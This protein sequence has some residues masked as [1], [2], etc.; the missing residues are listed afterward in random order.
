MFR[1]DFIKSS[2]LF[3]IYFA[4]NPA[5]AADILSQSSKP[6]K[7]LNDIVVNNENDFRIVVKKTEKEGVKDIIK[8]CE[9]SHYEDAWVYIPSKKLWVEVG[10]D[11]ELHSNCLSFGS[12]YYYD[13]HYLE[14]IMDK[15]SGN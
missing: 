1:R 2:V 11:E 6:I 5:G 3:S 10:I 8:L 14:S 15:F 9:S 7:Y 13:I 12:S 4:M